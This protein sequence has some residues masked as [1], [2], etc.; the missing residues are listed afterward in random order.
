MDIQLSDELSNHINRHLCNEYTKGRPSL[1][2]YASA[3]L[4]TSWYES[5]GD[6]EPC[7]IHQNDCYYVI[8]KLPYHGSVATILI[9]PTIECS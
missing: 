8:I 3:Q 7:I 4:C 1:S 9:Y 5:C 6:K 2:L